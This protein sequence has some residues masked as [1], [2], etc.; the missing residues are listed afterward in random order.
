MIRTGGLSPPLAPPA[1][2]A[3]PPPPEPPQPGVERRLELSADT[4]RPLP[5]RLALLDGKACDPL[6]DPGYRPL[7]PEETALRVKEIA[8]VARRRDRR[9]ALLPEAR[10]Q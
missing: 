2:P 5:H 6:Q 3:P 9:E 8:L 4:V 7:L 10:D 1:P